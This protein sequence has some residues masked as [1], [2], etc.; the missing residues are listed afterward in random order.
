MSTKYHSLTISFCAGFSFLIPPVLA[1]PAD[2]NAEIAATAH[3]ERLKYDDFVIRA[4]SRIASLAET[5]DMAENVHGQVQA[6]ALFLYMKIE[7]KNNPRF[8]INNDPLDDEQKL[9][10]IALE[11]EME[12]LNI[13]AFVALR[14]A[15]ERVVKNEGFGDQF[16]LDYYGE[17]LKELK[18]SSP[19]R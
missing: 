11:K 4:N 9:Q 8:H 3:F 18:T 19:L 14:R 17:K 2:S 10:V 16:L 5:A 15:C 13:Q 7:S 6:Y 1:A 12:A